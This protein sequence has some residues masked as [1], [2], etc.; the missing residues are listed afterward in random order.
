MNEFIEKIKQNDIGKIEENISLKTLTTYKAG[1]TAK[2]VVYPNNLDKLILLIKLIKEYDINYIIIGKG[3]N[4]LFSD[5]EYI[6]VIIKLDN[7][8]K[9]EFNQNKVYVES[10]VPLSKLVIE[11]AKRNLTGLEFAIGI[12]G[13]V[14][15]AIYMN[16]GAYG[17]NMSSIVKN[18]TVL[19]ENLEIEEIPIQNI[20]FSYRYS[21]LQDN[22]NLICIGTTI[23]L[24]YGKKEEI[25][26]KIKENLTKRKNTQPLEYPSAGSVFR[27][28]EGNYAGKLIEELKL[29]GLSIGGA[30]ISTKH[31]NFIIN[32]NNA[33]S[34]DILKLIKLVQSKVKQK[35]NIELKLE[36][37]LINW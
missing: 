26:N 8:N 11:S 1:G 24:E 5:K 28:P 30:E 33:T 29:K 12:P 17:S 36:Q 22:K 18:I 3:S 35:Y 23:E 14:G 4:T 34:D 27:N 6:G 32:K 13:N 25:D 10:G 37:Q 15:G 19:N 7:L 9:I 16:A 20:N 21:I 2:L 31:A